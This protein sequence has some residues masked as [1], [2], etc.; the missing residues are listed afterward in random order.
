MNKPREWTLTLG[1]VK[2]SKGK[3]Q[4]I[5]ATGPMPGPHDRIIVREA[6]DE[7]KTPGS[8]GK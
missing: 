6:T 1:T 7:E 8:S 5:V 3:T 2:T 4:V